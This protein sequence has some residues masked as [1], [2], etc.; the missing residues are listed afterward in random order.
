MAIGF[1][2]GYFGMQVNSAS[3]RR[4][5]F[6]VWSPQDTNDPNSVLPENAVLLVEKGKDTIAKEFGGE[7]SGG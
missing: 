2:G 1:N 4:I 3:E 6:S 5:L 7:G